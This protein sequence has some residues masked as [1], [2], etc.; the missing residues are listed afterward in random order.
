MKPD[1][2]FFIRRFILFILL[3]II[4]DQLIGFTL[5][6]V[7]FSQRKGQ[8]AQ[9]TYAVDSTRQDIL[10]F[11]SSRAVRH[12][13]PGIL[14]DSLK[15]SC[16][17]TGRDGQQIPYYTA[18]LEATL[19]R[20]TPK[21]ILLDVN[22]WELARGEGKYE[23]LSVLLPYC[24]N[25]PELRSYVE[26][27]GKWEKLKLWSRTYPYNSSLFILAYNS[28][29][30]YKLPAEDNGYSPLTG[31][32]TE[33]M[34]A[35]HKRTMEKSKE[36]ENDNDPNIDE[37]ALDYFRHFLSLTKQHHIKTYVIISPK[38]LKEPINYRV[39][40]LMEVAGEFGDV[41]FINFSENPA[42]NFQYRKFADVFHLNKEGS[43]EFTRVLVSK[44][45]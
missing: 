41:R 4:T 44:L 5:Q 40:K 13:V 8:F 11:G 1:L 33:A 2:L 9:V 24:R 34:F 42:F 30:A 12:Y 14:S 19:K 43:E 6:K 18:V 17:N 35:D 10:V 29:F 25:H 27:G 23:K 31:E 38:I 28:L 20:Y 22:S 7:Y 15:M 45:K 36:S 39:R 21:M 16:Y 37:K 26:Q 3:V 32:M